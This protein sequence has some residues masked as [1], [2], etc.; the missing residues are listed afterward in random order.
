MGETK[1]CII[2]LKHPDQEGWQ[3]AYISI[4]VSCIDVNIYAHIINEKVM[5]HSATNFG[6]I[7]SQQ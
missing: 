2:A 3:H 1:T 7:F 4:C 6:R 5:Q